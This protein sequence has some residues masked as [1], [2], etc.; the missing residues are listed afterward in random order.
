M[1]PES[2]RWLWRPALTELPK[3]LTEDNLRGDEALSKI[4]PDG[5]RPGDWELVASGLGFTDA[6]CTGPDG[7]LYFCDM[8]GETIYRIGPGDSAPSPWFE[9]SPRVSGM[10][11]GPG[12]TLYAAIRFGERAPAIVPRPRIAIKRSRPKLNDSPFRSGDHSRTPPREPSALCRR[13]EHGRP[14]RRR[15]R[16]SNERAGPRS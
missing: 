9:G 12:G 14:R 7:S 16:G 2:L 3:P 11:F 4:V 13:P 8:P 6:A 5:G 1:L 10:K 15:H